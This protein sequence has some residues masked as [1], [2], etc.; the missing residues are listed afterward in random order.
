[1]YSSRR[2]KN[3]TYLSGTAN[4]PV[5]SETVEGQ[6]RK[7]AEIWGYLLPWYRVSTK[8]MF[9]SE[10][11]YGYG[12]SKSV[13]LSLMQKSH[14][15]ERD[16]KQPHLKR[17]SRG[18]RTEICGNPGLP[19]VMVPYLHQSNVY[20]KRKLRAWRV[21]KYIPLIGVKT[22]LTCVGLQT[23][24]SQVSHNRAEN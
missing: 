13:L 18:P 14:F 2:Y 10:E 6:E 8:A 1:M 12:E 20:I 15:S 3:L 21:Q 23:T 11:S 5:S 7:F 19:F 17:A 16:S 4:N 22:S 24:P 9:I